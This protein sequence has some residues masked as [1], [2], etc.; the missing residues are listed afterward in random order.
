VHLDVGS[1]RAWPLMSYDQLASLFPD[2]KT[3][4]LPTNGQPLARYDEARAELEGRGDGIPDM[5][6][7]K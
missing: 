7:S 5:L 1:V 2:G 3:V 6:Y 4:H